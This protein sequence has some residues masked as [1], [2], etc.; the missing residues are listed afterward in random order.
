MIGAPIF[1]GSDL[2]I[3]NNGAYSPQDMA[4][5]PTKNNS[6]ITLAPQQG[7]GC[8][9]SGPFVNS[10]INLGPVSLSGVNDSAANPLASGLGYNPRCLKR[11]LNV[12]SARGADDAN[13]THLIS[14][15]QDIASFQNEMEGP[16]A[17]GI[18]QL[19]VHTAG[20]FVVG[21]DPGG[22]FFASPGDPWFWFHH[23][24][25]DRTYW[26]WQNLGLPRRY[27]EV[28]GTLTFANQPPSRNA[29]LEDRFDLGVNDGYVG[30]QMKE[31]M[32]TT[33]GL[34]CYVYE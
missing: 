10:T 9:T 30:I 2:S 13:S 33:D 1:D 22:D 23:A 11:D 5:F 8:I 26:I 15:N 25:I 6:V 27:K 29:T 14:T 20:H 31:A 12:F 34:F 18:P 3:S 16:F 19:G 28:A 7:G 32:S 4:Y 21:G 17:L 24:Q